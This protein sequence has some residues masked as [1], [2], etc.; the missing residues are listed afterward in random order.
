MK[1]LVQIGL[2]MLV[3]ALISFKAD[4]L[5]SEHRIYNQP[6]YHVALI[7]PLHLH[8]PKKR[9]SDTATA[10]YDY[11][12]GVKM[13]LT[14]LEKMGMKLT[15]H[16]YDSEADVK[17]VD[18][19]F[20]LPEMLEMNTII[21][22]IYSNTHAVAEIFCGITKIPLISPFKFYE[23]KTR[24]TF[25]HI[26][27]VATD[28]LMAFGEGQA[29]ARL[30]PD[31]KLIIV[32]DGLGEHYKLRKLFKEGFEL[33]SDRQVVVVSQNNLAE[34]YSQSRI[35]SNVIVYA[36]TDSVDILKKLVNL[37]AIGRIKL[38]IP[39]DS[40]KINGFGKN[41][42][43]KGKVLF[44]DNNTYDKYADDI[45]VF[46]KI[47]RERF[48]WEANSWQFKGYDQFIWLGQSLMTFKQTYPSQL[49]NACYGGLMQQ[50]TL[51]ESR[52]GSFENGGCKM[53]YYN[54]KGIKVLAE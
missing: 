3:L 52:N 12:E 5:N 54:Q 43:I 7:L 29:L 15:L 9:K 10:V 41:D 17:R 21:G 53:V 42:L 44:G 27:L 51:R 22:P 39:K 24:D 26:N 33:A 19:I 2:A 30:F 11:Y 50:F 28:S 31:H 47:Y 38:S 1:K 4:K 6:E 18:S 8:D 40:K 45:L 20:Q 23:R 46:R 25:P 49:G 14:E 16:V 32:S 37:S 34:V 35:N 36:P 48:R 13:A